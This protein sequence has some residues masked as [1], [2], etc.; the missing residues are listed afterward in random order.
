MSWGLL[1]MPTVIINFDKATPG[2]TPPGWSCLTNHGTATK[3]AVVRDA[4]APTPP[5][6]FAQISNND[7]T[8]FPVAILDKPVF[9]NGEISVRL[10]PVAG[11]TEQVGGLVWRF[12]DPNHYYLVRANARENTV[13]LYRVEAGEWKPLRPKGAVPNVW[14]VKHTVP[15]NS[16]SIL[17]V[18]FRGPVFSIYFNHRRLFQVED[19]S[20]QGAGKVG[21]WTRADSVT[22]FD[23]FRVV[24]K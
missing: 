23:D 16:W 9:P 20:Y 15:A 18:V 13:A 22:Y 17:K 3:W 21:L 14:A 11:K 12:R 1:G 8:Q 10:K 4:T 6:V 2:E 5:Y 7:N 19:R 24:E